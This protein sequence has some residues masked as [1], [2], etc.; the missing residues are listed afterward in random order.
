MQRGA[1][2]AQKRKRV[3]NTE[4]GRVAPSEWKRGSGIRNRKI[5]KGRKLLFFF[6]RADESRRVA[7]CS[8]ADAL[9][10]ACEVFH[11]YSVFSKNNL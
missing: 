7:L 9:R 5:S 2:T 6:K 8:N 10:R 3:I 4:F 11:R 1:Q